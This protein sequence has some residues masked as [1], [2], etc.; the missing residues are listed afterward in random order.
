MIGHE[1][2]NLICLNWCQNI[3]GQK[4]WTV[5]GQALLTAIGHTLCTL[6][7]LIGLKYVL[8]IGPNSLS[9]IGQNFQTLIGIASCALT[10]LEYLAVIGQEWETVFGQKPIILTVRSLGSDLKWDLDYIDAGDDLDD[11]VEDGSELDIGDD[12]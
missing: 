6:H 5:V 10:E 3:I 12:S 7:D 2:D 4:Y 8:G 11:Y 1:S 9:V